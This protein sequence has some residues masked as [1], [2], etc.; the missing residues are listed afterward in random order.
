MPVYEFS[1]SNGCDN[2][3]VWRS[4]DA[5]QSETGCPACGGN[6][7]RVFNPPMT[8]S[9]PLRLKKENSEPSV[10]RRETRPSAQTARLKQNNSRPWM[11]NRGC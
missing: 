11:L 2:Y 4:I 8:L 9:G 5:R 6:G 10:V 1:C 7:I 3:E